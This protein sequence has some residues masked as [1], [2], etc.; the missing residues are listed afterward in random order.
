MFWN[1][2]FEW[3]NF[4]VLMPLKNTVDFR[5]DFLRKILSLRLESNLCDCDEFSVNLG[6]TS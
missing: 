4:Y 5:A 2:P 1:I 6:D 3:N